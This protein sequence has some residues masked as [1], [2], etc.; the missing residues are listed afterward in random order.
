M[1]VRVPT[2]KKNCRRLTFSPEFTTY[3]VLSSRPST[4]YP[5]YLPRWPYRPISPTEV[6]QPPPPPTTSHAVIS[7]PHA[8]IDPPSLSRPTSPTASRPVPDASLL[9]PSGALPSPTPRHDSSPAPDSSPHLT[10]VPFFPVTSLL[11]TPPVHHFPSV[12]PTLSLS[13]SLHELRPTSQNSLSLFLAT[14]DSPSY[15]R[16]PT[17]PARRHLFMIYRPSYP[18]ARRSILGTLPKLSLHE[19]PDCHRS[20]RLTLSGHHP[21]DLYSPDNPWTPAFFALH[22]RFTIGPSGCTPRLLRGDQPVL[23]YCPFALTPR[24]PPLTSSQVSESAAA[25]TTS[26]RLLPAIRPCHVR[27]ASTITTD[28]VRAPQVRHTSLPPLTLKVY[29]LYSISRA[30]LH[31]HRNLV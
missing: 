9:F 8:N 20:P 21:I 5:P 26:L 6:A 11:R 24:R 10:S 23:A 2:E 22:T 29:I 16:F 13:P 25:P 19:S 1:T 27:S 17:T 30:C 4:C 3:P 31:C 15:W 28:R 14:I 12:L 18:D 7:H